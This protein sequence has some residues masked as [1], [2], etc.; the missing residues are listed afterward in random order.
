MY[1]TSAIT[2]NDRGHGRDRGAGLF[3]YLV[4]GV[5]GLPTHIF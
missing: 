5:S 2:V 3:D 1:V 4:K